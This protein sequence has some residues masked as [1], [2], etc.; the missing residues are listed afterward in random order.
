MK[1]FLTMEILERRILFFFIKLELKKKEN[2]SESCLKWIK[3]STNKAIG[4]GGEA[5]SEP[6]Q[7]E[8]KGKNHLS[9]NLLE[10]VNILPNRIMVIYIWECMENINVKQ[11]Y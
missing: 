7:I 9:L 6:D 5:V 8:K 2:E 1:I 4:K 11:Y 10:E 3:N